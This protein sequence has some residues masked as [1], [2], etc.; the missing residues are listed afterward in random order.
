MADCEL[1]FAPRL[2]IDIEHARAQH[3]DYEQCLAR[4]GCKI[5]QLPPEPRLPDSVFIEDTA[6]VF[7]EIAVMAR[8]GARSRRAETQS[9]AQELARRRRVTHIR[10]PGTLDGGDVLAVGREVFVG[11]ST[12]TNHA[13]FE[14]MRS[15]LTPL[16]YRV[17][18][19]PVL[20]TL[21]LKSAVTLVGGKI[22]LINRNWTDASVLESALADGAETEGAGRRVGVE[23]V[24]VAPSEPHAANALLIGDSVVYP[25]GYPLTK[26]RLEDR[27]IKVASVD[28]SE[29][30]KAEGAVTCCSLVFREEEGSDFS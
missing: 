1:T 20:G 27:G 14:Q 18:G 12:R 4:L 30:A 16:E 7:D 26:R 13:G 17:R 23:F 21:H 28:I 19:V 9:V 3:R 6:V 25:V 24:D 11:V 22:L 2:E 15:L 29:L 5:I 10:P 8:P